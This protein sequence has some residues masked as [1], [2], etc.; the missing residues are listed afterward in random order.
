MSKSARQTEGN[1]YVKLN[2]ET[3]KRFA[4]KEEK[5]AKKTSGDK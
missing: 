1:A 5:P 2:A 3:D 4:E